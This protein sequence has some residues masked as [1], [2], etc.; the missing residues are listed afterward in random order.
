[1]ADDWT[2]TGK[3]RYARWTTIYYPN[4]PRHNGTTDGGQLRLY[5]QGDAPSGYRDVQ[6]V[7]DRLVMFN[8]SAMPHEVRPTFF[9]RFAITGWFYEC[10]TFP[11]DDV[12]NDTD[13]QPA[14]EPPTLCS[15][16]N[17]YGGE[18]HEKPNHAPS[19]A[20]VV[21]MKAFLHN[22]CEF[23]V[24]A[25]G[26]P[27][28]PLIQSGNCI[29]RCVET[30]AALQHWQLQQR[31]QHDSSEAAA[32][33]GTPVD[34]ATAG[35]GSAV[36]SATVDALGNQMTAGQQLLMQARASLAKQVKRP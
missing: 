33:S 28:D 20:D 4:T 18:Q 2:P 8:A 24:C 23:L 6:P 10:D 29:E 34:G 14:A 25:L 30:V 26:P 5:T 32:A 9:R 36:T 22:Q 1:M 15:M 13:G 21:A 31:E 12:K 3:S 11:F 27:D 19:A 16:P 17:G 7:A 35:G